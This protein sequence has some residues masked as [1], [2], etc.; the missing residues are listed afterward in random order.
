MVPVKICGTYFAIF[1]LFPNVTTSML[2]LT[3]AGLGESLA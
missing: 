1:G 2:G 3:Q